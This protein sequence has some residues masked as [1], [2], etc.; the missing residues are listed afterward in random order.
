MIELIKELKRVMEQFRVSPEG[1]SRYIGCAAKSVYRWIQ[2]ESVP[3]LVYR[4]RIRDAIEK[5]RAD[6]PL[7][8]D[9]HIRKGRSRLEVLKD[10]LPTNLK[11]KNEKKAISILGNMTRQEVSDIFLY[12]MDPVDSPKMM[13]EK[14]GIELVKIK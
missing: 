8:E 2:E 10:F 12:C 11:V 14:F 5:M 1:A 6:A 3:T 13:K 9:T 7:I 4:D